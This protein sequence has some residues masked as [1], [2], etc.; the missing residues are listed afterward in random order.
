MKQKDFRQ[1]TS[2]AVLSKVIGLLV[3]VASFCT[4]AHAQVTIG[5][6]DSPA[7]GAL[8]DVKE[9]NGANGGPTSTKGIL[10]PR[11]ALDA[12][13]LLSPL[14]SA[15][16]N[17]DKL[18]H[19]GIVVYNITTSGNLKEGLYSWNGNE[20]IY[21]QGDPQAWD[22]TGNAG[23]DPAKNYVGTSDAQPLIL[24][25]NNHEGL[26]IAP[27]G[28]VTIKNTPVF[29]S[30]QSEV[31][32]KDQD[33]KIGV[34]TATP[35]KLMLIQSTAEQSYKQGTG[36]LTVDGK[37]FNTGGTVNARAVLWKSNEIGTNNIMDEAPHNEG[38]TFEYFIFKEEGL[39]EVSGFILYDPSCKYNDVETKENM[40]AL[41]VAI[42]KQEGASSW[43]NIAA[44]RAIW[45]G[46]AVYG[47]ANSA[48]VPPITA[49]FK[50]GDKIRLVFYRPI[51]TLG[52]PHGKSADDWGITIVNGI[53]VKKGLRI[54][55][56]DN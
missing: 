39:Y 49:H 8:L 25:A 35:A 10:F 12:P 36:D 3:I 45:S 21:V 24:K 16:T 48:Y 43:D 50:P 33:G 15:A 23:T 4:G 14:V 2:K 5:S 32:V 47:T 46:G 22:M 19:K 52:L 6:G 34:A 11:V 18:M 55:M 20:W 17:T 26:R 30:A 9:Q 41:N 29:H 54:M 37:I 1:K 28:D 44:I 27:N 31:L 53:N 42:Q 38:E 7:K 56:I 13:D 51:H 40:A